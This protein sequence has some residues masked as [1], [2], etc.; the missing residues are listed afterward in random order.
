[1]FATSGRRE[2]A[3]NSG[4]GDNSTTGIVV[5]IGF[6]MTN[7]TPLSSKPT[8]DISVLLTPDQ[9]AKFDEVAIAIRRRTGQA[10]SRSAMI[11]AIIHPVLAYHQHWLNCES[12]HQLPEGR[13]DAL[14]P[15]AA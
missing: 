6:V 1:V 11:R 13:H 10:I 5:P 4:I 14:L 12:E 15:E 7:A 8:T 9:I 3:R 2:P